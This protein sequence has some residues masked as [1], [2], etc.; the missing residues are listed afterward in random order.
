[1]Q[2]QQCLQEIDNRDEAIKNFEIQQDNFLS[3]ENGLKEDLEKLQQENIEL[4]DGFE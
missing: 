4:R 1:M 3:H 2:L